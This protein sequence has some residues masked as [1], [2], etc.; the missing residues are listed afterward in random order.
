MLDDP[1]EGATY[2]LRTGT[3]YILEKYVTFYLRLDGQVVKGAWR[4]HVVRLIVHTACI[5]FWIPKRQ[6][7]STDNGF[8]F[9]KKIKL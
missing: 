8:I 1:I 9:K 4:V 2:D 6:A 5:S 3:V 7:I